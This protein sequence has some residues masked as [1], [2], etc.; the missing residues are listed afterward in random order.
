MVGVSGMDCADRWIVVGVSGM[1]C[2]YLRKC[3]HKMC[4]IQVGQEVSVS[5][6]TFGAMKAT[7]TISSRQLVTV[8]VNTV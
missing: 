8:S 6:Q 1:D 3:A 2:A 7:K 4:Y 5:P